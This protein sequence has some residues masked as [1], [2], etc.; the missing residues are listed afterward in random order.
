MTEQTRLEALLVEVGEQV[1]WPVER[2]L[3]PAIRTRLEGATRAG[4]R[5]ARTWLRPVLALTF[6]VIAFLA[7]GAVLFPGARQ[8]VADWLGISGIEIRV[9]DEVHA[10]TTDPS[11]A[12]ELQLGEAVS[13][14]EAQNRVDFEVA[15]P[16]RVEGSPRVFFS[17]TPGEG[18]VSLVYP[19]GGGLPETSQIGVGL[20]LT[21]FEAR[22]DEVLIKKVATGGARVRPVEIGEGGYWI[23]GSPHTIRYVGP[24]GETLEDQ[25]RLADDT[26]VWEEDGVSYR[27]ESALELREALAMARSLE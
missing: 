1:A 18:A 8:A 17:S 6:A 26:L 16:S 10:P 9:E 11:L 7:A 12:L 22:L 4:Q 23:E 14:E 20:L 15:R 21:Q 24:D 3:A 13:F 25:V 2:D 19:P 27:L 5:R